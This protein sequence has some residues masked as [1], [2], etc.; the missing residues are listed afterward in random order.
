MSNNVLNQGLAP[1][2]VAA[3][4]LRTLVP[5]LAPL[6]KIVTTDFSAY[7]AE[8]G[9]VVHTRFANK[10]VANTYVRANGFVPSDADATDVAIT[11]ADHKYVA[12]AFDDT[13]VATIS[14]DMLR[15]VFIAPMANATVKSLF[16]G[17]IGIT[18]EAN[19][20]G[21][22]Y[23]GTKAN[24]NRVAIAGA[25]TRMTKANLP[26][27]DRSMLL[28]PDAFG[29]LLQDASV[30]QYLSIGDTSVIRDGKVGRLH[31]IDIYEYNGFPGSGTTFTEKLNGIA[32]C[33]EG[34]VIVTRVPAAPTTGGGEQITVQDPESGFAFALRSWYDWTKGLSNVSAS[35]ITGES[36]GNPDAALRVVISDL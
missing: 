23:S 16:D 22:A 14:L 33:R 2:F 18:T 1:Q 11:L 30:A 25:A 15:R 35:W 12:A 36:V 28:T 27:N 7:V 13:E 24:F 3:E 6:N 19:Y 9:Q 17:V 20:A 5:V 10:F 21:L 26:M 34:H 31:G 29:Q 32:S 4:T 8:K